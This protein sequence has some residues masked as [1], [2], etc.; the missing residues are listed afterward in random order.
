MLNAKTAREYL[1]LTQTE[2]SKAMGISRGLWV[3]W[4]RKEQ[5]MTAA[6]IQ[7]IKI[8]IELD[9]KGCLK[10]YLKKIKKSVFTP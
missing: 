7:L 8:L 4:E 3:K 5:R 1:E 9:K 2:M 6:P 10:K